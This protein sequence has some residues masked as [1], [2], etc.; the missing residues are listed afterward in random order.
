MN[1]GAEIKSPENFKQ[2]I[3]AELIAGRQA[4]LLTELDLAGR[5]ARRLFI[6]ERA[7][8]L[9]E[10]TG[11]RGYLLARS[12]LQGGKLQFDADHKGKMLIAEPYFP[13]SR[14]IVLGGGHIAKPLVDFAAKCGFAVTVVDDRP[15]FANTAR[16]PQAERVI[17]ESFDRCFTLLNINRSAFVVIITR[18]HR[19]DIDCLRQLQGLETGYTG[20]IGSARRVRA[21]KQ[22]LLTEGYRRDQLAALQAPIGLDI[23]AL[24]PEEIAVSILSQVIQ[25]KRKFS[26]GYWP[27]LDEDVLGELARED[28]DMRALVTIVEAKGSVPRGVGAKML[29]WPYGKT[30]GSIGGGCSESGVIQKA[31]DVIRDGGW[32]MVEVDMTGEIAADAGM[33]CGGKIK[34]LIEPYC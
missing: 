33:V 10:D 34:V 19:H 6:S 21:V 28:N 8:S 24:T 2:T 25:Y 14:L 12:A 27:E 29:V 5:E 11:G 18:G 22:Q 7:L 17:C 15:A 23:G 31:Y 9:R 32:R 4:V 30:V 20:M 13:R 3:L 26:G 16:F 1:I